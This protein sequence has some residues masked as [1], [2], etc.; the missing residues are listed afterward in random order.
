MCTHNTGNSRLAVCLGMGTEPAGTTSGRAIFFF[1]FCHHEQGYRRNIDTRL[2]TN[3]S[4]LVF[5]SF[6]V[7][8]VLSSFLSSPV[9][10]CTK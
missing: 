8:R 3:D 10:C 6:L 5:L 1:F 4:F 9:Q 7:P 2:C